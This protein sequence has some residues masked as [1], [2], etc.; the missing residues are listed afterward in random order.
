MDKIGIIGYGVVGKAVEYGFKDNCT[1]YI[2][3]PAFPDVNV[4]SVEISITGDLNINI[5][6]MTA[7]VDGNIFSVSSL[8]NLPSCPHIR[9]QRSA[10]CRKNPTRSRL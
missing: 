10:R 2:Y 4:S 7:F 8:G 3:D 5:N 6:G 1:I 9:I